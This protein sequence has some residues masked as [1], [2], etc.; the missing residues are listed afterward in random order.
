MTT[1]T[2]SVLAHTQK[3][4]QNQPYIYK[5]SFHWTLN[6]ETSS[7]GFP[8]LYIDPW[9]SQATNAFQKL[10]E[11]ISTTITTP[12]TIINLSSSLYRS[13]FYFLH[14]N[15]MTTEQLERELIVFQSTYS[16]SFQT[17][18]GIFSS[19]TDKHSTCTHT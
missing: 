7:I 17:C 8:Y 6:R 13:C 11:E 16:I 9:F 10:A 15:F 14:R 4:R 19:H 2:H 3:T 12:T 5:R 1:N 18:T